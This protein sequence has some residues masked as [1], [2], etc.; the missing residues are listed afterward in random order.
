MSTPRGTEGVPDERQSIATIN[1]ALELGITFFDTADVY[2][3]YVNEQ[4]LGRVLASRRDDVEVATKFGFLSKEKGRLVDGRPEWAVACC[5]S[6]LKNL[7]VDV[8]TLFYLHRVDPD[9][10]VEETVGAMAGLVHAGKVR[11]LGLSE[12]SGESLR[13]ANA[14]HP[15]T[16]VQ[17]EYS[18]WTREPEQGVLPVAS[19]LGVGFVPF[20]PLGRGFLAGTIGSLADVPEGDPRR[21]LPR[22]AEENIAANRRMVLE[23][24]DMASA[25][26]ISPAQLALAWLLSRRPRVV[27]IPG[28]TSPDRLAENVAAAGVE[29][30]VEEL[31]RIDAIVPVGSAFGERYAETMLRFTNG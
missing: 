31:N 8:I 9:V 30:R 16:A 3:P 26:G 7:G 14:I 28:T 5:E 4:L 19:E 27:P 6:S 15:I 13:R 17:S 21:A 24:E 22:F 25:K 29:L 1:R 2:G 20:A 12:A 23:I 10:P 18:L 11:Y